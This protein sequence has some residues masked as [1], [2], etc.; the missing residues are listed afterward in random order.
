MVS[1]EIELVVAVA[2]AG[3]LGEARA[4]V[5]G[6]ADD[7]RAPHVGVELGEA[8]GVLIGELAQAGEERLVVH[9][10]GHVDP[11]EARAREEA[12]VAGPGPGVEE[13]A[14]AIAEAAERVGVNL[15][16]EAADQRRP[17][18]LA[19][20]G[21]ARRVH[22]ALHR[23]GPE[24]NL[25]VAHLGAGDGEHGVVSPKSFWNWMGPAPEGKSWMKSSRPW[26]SSHSLAQSVTFS[27]R[28][29]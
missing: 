9:R 14:D 3:D 27:L 18:P 2:V 8:E 26:M 22:G 20:S 10:R 25:D 19:A 4:G 7:G 6:V 12:G 13:A 24:V 17:R 11:D 23:G 15:R 16:G 29:T 28:V 1:V 5:L 21:G